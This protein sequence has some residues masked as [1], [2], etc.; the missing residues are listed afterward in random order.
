MKPG[1]MMAAIGIEH[2]P[3]A[4]SKIG[5]KHKNM[6]LTNGRHTRSRFSPWKPE[7]IGCQPKTANRMPE[8]AN[9]GTAAAKGPNRTACRMGHDLRGRFSDQPWLWISRMPFT[10]H[11]HPD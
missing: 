10:V 9:R 5:F 6:V 4:T 8:Y 3:N 2:L 11:R 7:P 1:Q